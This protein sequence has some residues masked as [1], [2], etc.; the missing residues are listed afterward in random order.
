MKPL[1]MLLLVFSIALTSCN[2]I[3]EELKNKAVRGLI[4]Y[5]EKQEEVE[6][7][8]FKEA[9]RELELGLAVEG[10]NT[11]KV[12]E[13]LEQGYDPNRSRRE[14][15]EETTPLGIIVNGFYNTFTREQ[16]GRNIPDPPPDVATLQLLVEAGAD[17]NQRPYIWTR[18]TRYE[19]GSME[20]ILRNDVLFTA[21]GSRV[22]KTEHEKEMVAL[23]NIEW[24]RHYVEDSNRVIEAFL[25]VGADPDMLGHPYP[26][27]I[28]ADRKGITDEEA[29]EYFARGTR[30]INEAIKK[31]IRWESQVDLLLQ[32]TTLDED[33]LEAAEESGDPEMVEKITRLW[34]EQQENGK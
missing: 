12:K 23:Q 30:P 15:W 10:Y 26:F 16:S 33:S 2:K 18:V 31:G 21:D 22:V 13:Y 8:E 24:N 27:S 4:S 17:V 5:S 28:E 20:Q 3:A 14:F 34:A 29:A 32:Y 7:P 6:S 19:N 1:L 11:D 25:K 9:Q